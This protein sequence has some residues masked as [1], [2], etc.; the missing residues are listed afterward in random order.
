MPYYRRNLLVLSLTIFLAALSWNQVVPFLPIFIKQMGVT[1][2]ALYTWSG[3]SIAIPSIAA[4]FAQVF[5][6]KV[7]DKYGRKPMIIRAG[8][9]LALAYFFM[10][11][12]RTP[13]QLAIIRFLSGALTGFIPGSVAL[14]ATNTPQEEAPRAMA[15][16]QTMSAV[17]QIAGPSI[18]FALAQI[19]GYR[20]S[21]QVSGMAVAFSTLLALILV[22]EPNK[23]QIT[24][25]TNMLEDLMISMRSPVISSLVVPVFLAGTFGQAIFSVLSLQLQHMGGNA[26]KSFEG[27]VYA[28]PAIAFAGTAYFWTRLGERFSFSLSMQIG[29]VGTAISAVILTTLNNIYAFSGVF[30]FAGISVA[31]IGPSMAAIL[32]TKVSDEFRARA[33][34]FQ[35]AVS[36][37]GA[38]LSPLA[39]GRIAASFGIPYVYTFLGILFAIGSLTYPLMARRWHQSVGQQLV[40]EPELVQDEA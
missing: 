17:G 25:K 20:G 37:L 12:C 21:M 30:L 9:C 38:F 29:L 10:S 8:V 19:W 26:P 39:A 18:G 14:I 15:I 32:C 11:I 23:V 1:G 31:S 28:L 33:Y 4:I 24:A 22:K 6:I 36:S 2:K 3:V 16:A 35:S 34:G 5:W 27:I 7:G 40:A 13:F